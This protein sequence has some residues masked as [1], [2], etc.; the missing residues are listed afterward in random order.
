MRVWNRAVKSPVTGSRATLPVDQAGNLIVGQSVPLLTQGNLQ[1]GP[2]AIT[3]DPMSTRG[4]QTS[5]YP[6]QDGFGRTGQP[7]CVVGFGVGGLRRVVEFDY[8][9]A[10]GL[11][12]VNTDRVDVSVRANLG[13][14]VDVPSGVQGPPAVG[15]WLTPASQQALSTPLHLMNADAAAPGLFAFVPSFAKRLVVSPYNGA[16]ALAAGTVTLSFAAFGAASNWVYQFSYPA[17]GPTQPITVDVPATASSVNITVD[18]A[19]SVTSFWELS[20]A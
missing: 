15:A 4:Y 17:G 11:L 6:P 12:V 18:T 19:P 16:G 5:P 13:G 3:L 1:W 10:G 20:L 8:P 7:R 9:F 14:A 2:W